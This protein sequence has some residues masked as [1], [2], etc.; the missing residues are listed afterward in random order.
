MTTICKAIMN[1][2]RHDIQK[3]ND[4]NIKTSA[5]LEEELNEKKY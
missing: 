5:E 3:Y 4:G 1:I 2:N